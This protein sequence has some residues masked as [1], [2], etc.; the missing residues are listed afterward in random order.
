MSPRE[1][2]A[3]TLKMTKRSSEFKLKNFVFIFVSALWSFSA[4]YK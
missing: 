1:N 3:D 2:E 4:P